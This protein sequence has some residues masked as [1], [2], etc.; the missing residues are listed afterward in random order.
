ML[1]LIEYTYLLRDDAAGPGHQD[2]IL[3]LKGVF[4]FLKRMKDY[5]YLAF[6]GI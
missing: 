5:E 4:K 3:R 6:G 1:C 2:R